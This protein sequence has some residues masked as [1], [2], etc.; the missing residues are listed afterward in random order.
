MPLRLSS[1]VFAAKGGDVAMTMVRGKILYQ[2][3]SFPTIDLQ[4]V[5]QE[6]TGYAIDRLFRDGE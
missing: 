1:L 3:G 4:A 2:N 5:V 6:L